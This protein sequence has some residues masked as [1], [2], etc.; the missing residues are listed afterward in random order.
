[1]AKAKMNNEDKIDIPVEQKLKAL[2][3]LQQIDSKI[4]RIRIIRGELPL[5]V[6]DL[7]DEVLGL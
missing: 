2:F 7:E 4:D 6:H 5:D 3:E 1:M